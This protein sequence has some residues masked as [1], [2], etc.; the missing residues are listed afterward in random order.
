MTYSPPSLIVHK[1]E[2]LIVDLLLVENAWCQKQ[3]W[4]FMHL[5]CS[6]MVGFGLRRKLGTAGTERDSPLVLPP[7]PGGILIL[8]AGFVLFSTVVFL[9]DL[10]IYFFVPVS[11]QW[12]SCRDGWRGGPGRQIGGQGHQRGGACNCVLC[13]DSLYLKVSSLGDMKYQMDDLDVRY[14]ESALVVI[15]ICCHFVVL[16]STVNT[17][18]QREEQLHIR[19]HNYSWREKVGRREVGYPGS[20]CFQ[21]HAISLY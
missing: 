13:S 11:R 2:E 3:S 15:S 17:K 1:L 18:T 16:S 9:G 10:E 19:P 14:F 21:K 20:L 7:W 6:G 8:L 12:G 4:S 5:L